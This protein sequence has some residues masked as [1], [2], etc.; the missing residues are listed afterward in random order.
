MSVPVEHEWLFWDV[1]PG[2]IDLAR[3]RRYVLGRVLERGRMAD[4]RWV[5]SEYGT[6]GVHEFFRAGAHPEVSRATWSLWRA[7]FNESDSEWPTV[8][9]WR[10]NNA[11]PWID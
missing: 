8:P 6:E 10:N 5:V 9:D 1:D 3:D 11:A 4:V 2:A 7:F